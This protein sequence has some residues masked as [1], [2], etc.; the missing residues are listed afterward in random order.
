MTFTLICMRSGFYS[1]K[2]IV[3]NIRDKN[4]PNEDRILKYLNEMT[5][6][7]ENEREEKQNEIMEK[8]TEIQIDSLI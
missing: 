1:L 4:N 3:L 6:V 5:L 7:V 2:G 8:T